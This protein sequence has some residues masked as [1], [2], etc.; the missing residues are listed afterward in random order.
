VAWLALATPAQAQQPTPIPTVNFPPAPAFTGSPASPN[1]VT[2]IPATPQNPF[3]A[4]NG[5]SEIHDDGWQTDVNRWGGPLGRQ[6]QQVSN[7]LAI[8]LPPGP[9]RDCGTITFDHQGRVVAI[10]VGASGPTLYMFDPNTLE[11]LATFQLPPRQHLPGNIFQDFTGGGY[12]Y[13][14]NQD[15]VVAATTPHHL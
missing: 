14:D 4:P 12:F 11:T 3:M 6:P 8:G 10:C 13:L 9:G 7:W 5:E 15:R 2:G 1:P